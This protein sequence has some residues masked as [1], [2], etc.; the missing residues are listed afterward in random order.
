MNASGEMLW[1]EAV[2]KSR[3]KLPVFNNLKNLE[4]SFKDISG[5]FSLRIP[6]INGFVLLFP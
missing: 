6:L 3:F 4:G 1:N 2:A 5:E